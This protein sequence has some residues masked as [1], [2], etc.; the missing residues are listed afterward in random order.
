MT[1]VWSLTVRGISGPGI[2]PSCLGTANFD[3]ETG[4]EI[5]GDTVNA[6]AVA[7]TVVGA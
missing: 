7:I 4:A 2:E 5:G 3:D 6:F 1:A